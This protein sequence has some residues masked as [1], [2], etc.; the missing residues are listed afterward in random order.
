MIFV[1]FMT[2]NDTLSYRGEINQ[3]IHNQNVRRQITVPISF[4][5]DFNLEFADFEV[6]VISYILIISIVLG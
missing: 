4:I 3:S 2:Y 5:P 6:S 1:Y